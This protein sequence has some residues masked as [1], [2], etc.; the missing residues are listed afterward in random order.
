MGMP[1]IS[2]A[3]K[4]KAVTAITRS[5]RGIIACIIEDENYAAFLDNPYI[6]YDIND[7]PDGL[8]VK[9]KNRWN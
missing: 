5:Q 7:L 1:S 3:F 9:I 2:I 6:M 4:E 8:S